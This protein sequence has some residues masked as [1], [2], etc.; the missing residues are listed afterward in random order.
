M[1][2]SLDGRE[3]GKEDLASVVLEETQEHAN[4]SSERPA[5]L[6]VQWPQHQRG[7]SEQS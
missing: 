2:R 3:R 5:L 6:Q 7:Y 4:I 1:I